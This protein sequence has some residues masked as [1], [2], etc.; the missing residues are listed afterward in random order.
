[1]FE[2]GFAN[3]QTADLTSL[4]TKTPI[5]QAIVN[6]ASSDEKGGIMTFA[7]NADGSFLYS[8]D[9]NIVK[10]LNDNLDQLTLTS[11]IDKD[12]SAPLTKG[13]AY[14]KASIS[15][16]G[17][18]IVKLDLYAT[19]DMKAATADDPVS[20]VQPQETVNPEDI[21]GGSGI[22]P[23]WWLLFP[24]LLILILIIRIIIVNKKRRRRGRRHVKP[25]HYRIK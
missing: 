19:A 14:G 11:E 20:P 15:L 10:Q 23:W 2:W 22:S 3:N 7:P 5:T 24:A 9:A 1:M 16:N 4:F 8:G 12:L 6:A 25:Y 21:F 17:Q 13:Q 18:E